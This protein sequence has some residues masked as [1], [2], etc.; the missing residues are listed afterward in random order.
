MNKKQH[1]VK[2]ALWCI[3]AALGLLHAWAGRFYIEPDGVNYLDIAHAYVQH[4]WHN[5]VNAYWSPLYSWILA[6]ALWLTRV[7][8]YWESTLLHMVN[9]GFY[10]LA[11]ACFAFFFDE[12]TAFRNE[13][14][15]TS[16]ESAAWLVL[17]YA[18]FAYAALELIGLQTDT[19]DMFVFAMFFLATGIL[20]RIHRTGARWPLYATLGAVLAITYFSKTVM[21]PLAFVFLACTFFAAKEWKRRFARTVAAMVVFLA[22]AAPWVAALSKATARLTY[23][24]AGSLNYADYVN[25]L[26]GLP[27]WHGEIP[28]LGV[29]VHGTRTLNRMPPID[30]FATPVAGTYPPWFD[31]TYWDEGVRP[32]F[33]LR[34]QLRALATGASD[35]F[36]VLSAEK[37]LLVGF[38]ALLFFASGVKNYLRGFGEFWMAWLPALAAVAIYDM[39]H[40]ET[41]FV[42]GAI[43][44]LW[45]A[46]FGAI[47]LKA[48]GDQGRL[49]S[50]VTLAAALVLSFSIAG[51]LVSDAAALLRGQQRPEWEAAT[52]LRQRGLEPGDSVAILGKTNSA[53]YW[54]HLAQAHV[55]A[56]LPFDALG[57]YWQSTP[58]ERSRMLGLFATTGAKF[59]VTRVPPP[60]SAMAGWS[61]LGASGY[62]ALPLSSPDSWH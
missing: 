27:H 5:A 26:Q 10:L 29:P 18:I 22:L 13:L 37:G 57:E 23:G 31:M 42:G 49:W 3:A 59:L 9:F 24:D 38:L 32:H 48:P 41:R 33:E 16:E 52:A 58:E 47:T 8:L 51:G 53:D 60:N 56:D 19:P 17:G 54:A 34:G 45:C 1:K 28:G 55:V 62:Y 40:V 35:Y 25:G 50:S 43:A 12:L 14:I 21:F 44:V 6:L 20:I 36:H 15:G 4:D 30:E 61:P 39:V 46:V 7:P 2:T 11:L